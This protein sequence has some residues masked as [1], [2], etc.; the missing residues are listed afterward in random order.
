LTFYAIRRYS[1]NITRVGVR[2][3][4]INHKLDLLTLDTNQSITN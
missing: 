4:S 2:H 1:W 3:Q